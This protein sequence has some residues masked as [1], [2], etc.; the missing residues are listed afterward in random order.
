MKLY[1]IGSIAFVILGALHLAA[2]FAGSQNPNAD[3]QAVLNQMQALK[4]DL[5][6]QHDLLKFHNGFSIM[7]G[8]LL[9]VF[10][11]QN[12]IIA[13]AAT[14]NYQLSSILISIVLLLLSILYFHILATA[15]IFSSLVCYLV[16]YKKRY[17]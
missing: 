8:V 13:D 11:L 10:G 9:A 17:P 16:S 6:G 4:I 15:F 7:M 1:K 3:T 5:F 12:F 14:K 2:H